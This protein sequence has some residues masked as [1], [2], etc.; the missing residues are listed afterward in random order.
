MVLAR[1][2]VI[3]VRTRVVLVRTGVAL[4]RTGVVLARTGV[5]LARTIVVLVR[6]GVVLARTRVL[7]SWAY[8]HAALDQLVDVK[9]R[10]L[11]QLHGVGENAHKALFLQNEEA[12][13]AVSTMHRSHRLSQLTQHLLHA[14][15]VVFVLPESKTELGSNAGRVFGE[16]RFPVRSL[17]EAQGLLSAHCSSEE[18]DWPLS[19]PS[20]L[21][22]TR[23]KCARLQME[24][25]E[26][27]PLYHASHL[28]STYSP[29]SP[30]PISPQKDPRL[31][32]LI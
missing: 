13:G 32:R 17:A 18:S 31:V 4:V 21:L 23:L 15:A 30:A 11:E 19:S 3:L 14:V 6:T 12:M 24:S 8:L 25:P 26:S 27:S 10:L 2:R 1:T 20:V 22:T 28:Y 9:E 29:F 16:G 7:L 5:V